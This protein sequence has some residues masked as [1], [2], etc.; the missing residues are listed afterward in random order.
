MISE[1]QEAQHFINGQYVQSKSLATFPLINPAT[2]E[3]VANVSE[4]RVEDINAAVDAAEAAFP[5][6]S[7]TSAAVKAAALHKL[8]ALIRENAG[9][10]AKLE[11]VSMGM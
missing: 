3:L 10:L 8:A 6:W 1:I 5:A 4:A 9:H 11:S 2:E 7:K